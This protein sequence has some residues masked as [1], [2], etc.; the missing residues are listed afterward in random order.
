MGRRPAGAAIP[1]VCV[2]TETGV[3]AAQDANTHPNTRSGRVLKL[4]AIAVQKSHLLQSR[5][6]RALRHGS[7]PGGIANQKL[8]RSIDVSNTDTRGR[9]LNAKENQMTYPTSLSDSAK[10]AEKDEADRANRDPI[11]GAPGAHPVGTALGG[12]S[13]GV[14]GA[15]AGTVIAGPV[16]AVVGAVVGVIAGGL[17]GKAAGEA[18][19]PTEEDIYWRSRFSAEPYYEKGRLYDDYAPAYRTGYEA[20]TEQDGLSFE[21]SEADLQARY[22]RY[23]G[24]SKLDWAQA[25]PATR[26]AWDRADRAAMI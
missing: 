12:T 23:R 14:A 2:R 25:R 6:L 21:Q 9:T 4:L 15:V 19:N 13:G 24:T 1:C 17:A 10:L 3:D 7:R 26:A 16:G 22:L 20:R 5:R 11:T 8:L 18:A